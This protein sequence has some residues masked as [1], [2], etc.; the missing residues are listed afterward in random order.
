MN[1]NHTK[2]TENIERTGL[3]EEWFHRVLCTGGRQVLPSDSETEEDKK[4]ININE[5][6]LR[7]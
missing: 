5:V 4:K 2:T 1:H 6:R 7:V 3:L